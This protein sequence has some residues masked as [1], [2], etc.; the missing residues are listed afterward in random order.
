MAQLR[1]HRSREDVHYN[2]TAT[3]LAAAEMH[4]DPHHQR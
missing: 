1:H 2:A 3:T 4:L